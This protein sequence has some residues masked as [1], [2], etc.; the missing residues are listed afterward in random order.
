MTVSFDSL[1]FVSVIEMEK[2]RLWTLWSVCQKNIKK[3]SN[4]CGDL[5][6]VGLVYSPYKISGCH[7]KLLRCFL[8]ISWKTGNLTWEKKRGFWVSKCYETEWE[9]ILNSHGNLSYTHKYILK[10]AFCN[11]SL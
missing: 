9:V 11:K 4:M 2:Q 6:E 7:F 5:R 8:F 1:V 10:D 3:E